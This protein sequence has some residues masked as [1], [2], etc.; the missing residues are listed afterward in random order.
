[1]KIRKTLPG[2]Y[3]RVCRIYADARKFM[4]TTG[5]PHQWKNT[6]PT[7]EIVL[8][9]I[10]RGLSY[11]CVIENDIVAVFYYN[12]EI[13]PTY[14]VIDGM[15]LNDAPYGVVHRIASSR[16]VKGA[17]VFCLQWCLDQCQ[18]LRIDTHKDNIPM[19]NLLEK[20]DFDYCGIIWIENGEER[21]AY[22]KLKN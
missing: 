3:E 21:L 15:W 22:Q 5:N 9:D 11:V 16:K 17:G 7:T 4:S 6:D 1:M 14:G 2:D 13:D 18:N 12:I 10:E 19:K 20:L 8:Q